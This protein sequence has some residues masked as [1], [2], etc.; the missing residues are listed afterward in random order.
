VEDITIRQGFHNMD[1]SVVTE[2]LSK[3]FW[4]PDIKI[5]EVI[6]GAE[7]SAL[8]IGVFTMDQ[9]QIGYARVIS[10]KTRFAYILDVYIDEDYRHQGIGQRLIQ[11]ILECE[12]L[13]DVYQWQLITKDAHTFYRKFGFEPSKRIADILEIRKQRPIR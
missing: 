6:K 3:S 4:C 11:S 2:M 1:F 10:D 13:Q 7:N 5:A 12:E 9:K 8:V